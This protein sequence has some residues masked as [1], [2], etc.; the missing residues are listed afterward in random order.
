MLLHWLVFFLSVFMPPIVVGASR[1]QRQTF[2]YLKLSMVSYSHYSLFIA[3]DMLYFVELSW[4]LCL[5]ISHIISMSYISHST[6]QTARYHFYI[7]IHFLSIFLFL[8]LALS[9]IFVFA[10]NFCSHLFTLCAVWFVLTD[11]FLSVCYTNR[12]CTH[13]T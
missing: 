7:P 3:F 1:F 5:C 4:C 6:T 8:S 11:T 13:A 9:L 2:Y 12:H 10:F